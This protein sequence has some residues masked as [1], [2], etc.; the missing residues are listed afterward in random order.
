[1]ETIIRP[2][3]KDDLETLREFQQGIV[4]HERPFDTGIPKEGEVEYY[5]IEKLLEDEKTY[6]VVAEIGNSLVGCGFGQIRENL[7]WEVHPQY[8][9]VGLMYVK[10]EYRRK[11]IARRVVQTLI[12][13]FGERG[14]GHIVIQVY[15]ENSNAVAAY[16]SYGFTDFLLQMRFDPKNDDP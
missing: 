9:Y 4:A 5:D 15:H 16:R 14:I 2:A 6:F 8:G 13:W 7:P 1:M 12:S 11:E 3:R 10:P